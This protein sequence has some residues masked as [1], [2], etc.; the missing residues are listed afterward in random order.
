MGRQ[1]LR[2]FP[3]RGARMHLKPMIQGLAAVWLVLFVMSFVA[4]ETAAPVDEATADLDRVA[5]FLTWQVLAFS[6]AGVGAITTRYAVT[7]GAEKVKV[8]GYLPLAVSVFLVASFIVILAARLYG[9]PFL[10]GM[11]FI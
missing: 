4:L 10:Q 9:M 5:S 8:F 11:G 1:R 2:Y 3:G 7:R 6:I